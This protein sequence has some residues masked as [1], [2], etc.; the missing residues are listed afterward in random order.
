MLTGQTFTDIPKQKHNL[1]GGGNNFS[2]SCLNDFTYSM[3]L[4]V[5]SL[6]CMLIAA[7][8]AERF[9]KFLAQS[10]SSQSNH[11]RVDPRAA[12]S[13]LFGWV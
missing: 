7:L 2:A 9:K 1:F 4:M 10:R 11:E 12:L 3:L 8:Q 6:R 5:F 13:G